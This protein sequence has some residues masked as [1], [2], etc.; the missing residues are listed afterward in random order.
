M[1]NDP[2][3][4]PLFE[5]NRL[6]RE[7]TENAIVSSMF[8]AGLKASEPLDAFSTW[9]LAGTAAVAAFMVTNADRLMPIIN[10]KGFLA[11][12]AFLCISCLCGLI[13][14]MFALRCRIQIEAGSAIRQTFVERLEIHKQEEEKIKQGASFWGISLETGIRIDRVLAEF[15]KP[16]PNWVTWIAKRQLKKHAGNPQIGH[17]LVISN[18]NRQGLF[19]TLQT[20]T[21]LGFLIAGFFFAAS[22]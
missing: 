18:L 12:G 15:Y 6:A 4:K 8:E 5:W 21:F 9:L 14:K 2:R 19:T 16:L 13:S 1:E 11:C 3:L 17:Y 22:K 10:Q 20:L 7:N